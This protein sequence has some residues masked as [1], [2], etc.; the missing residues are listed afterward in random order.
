MPK[1][2]TA[3]NEEIMR[4]EDYKLS[5]QLSPRTHRLENQKLSVLN[6][7]LKALKRS[8]FSISKKIFAQS[9]PIK[10]HETGRK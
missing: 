7:N 1:Q 10:F 6:L 8:R 3:R 2:I 9:V 5:L 4:F